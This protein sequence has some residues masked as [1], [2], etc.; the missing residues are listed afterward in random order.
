MATR[1]PALVLAA[2][3]ALAAA[4]PAFADRAGQAPLRA[5]FTLKSDHVAF[6]LAGGPWGQAFGDSGV[7][8]VFGVYFLRAKRGAC[9]PSVEVAGTAARHAPEVRGR[10]VRFQGARYLRYSARLGESA[11][12]AACAA[13]GRRVLRRIVGTMHIAAGP[14][15]EPPSQG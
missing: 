10:T 15:A 14:L 3:V 2:A 4:G 8:P 6:T 9:A 5:P 11:R 12:S 13:L 1:A 7:N